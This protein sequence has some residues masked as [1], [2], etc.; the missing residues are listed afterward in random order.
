MVLVR[1]AWRSTPDGR[2]GIAVLFLASGQV[3]VPH[4]PDGIGMEITVP[5]HYLMSIPPV[6]AHT[7]AAPH[8]SGSDR[9]R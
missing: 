3:C 6:S 7:H 4:D 8:R 2:A 9:D 1:E 5:K